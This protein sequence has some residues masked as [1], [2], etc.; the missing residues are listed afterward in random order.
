MTY[1][2]RNAHPRT[3]VVLDDTAGEGL[4]MGCGCVLLVGLVSGCMLGSFLTWVVS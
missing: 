2:D 3:R 4:L 1:Q